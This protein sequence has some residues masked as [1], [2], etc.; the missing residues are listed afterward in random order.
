M[1]APSWIPFM[2]HAM[3]R[4]DPMS[5]KSSFSFEPGAVF[6]FGKAFSETVILLRGISGEVVGAV[7]RGMLKQVSSWA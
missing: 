6:S 3:L 1:A 5:R 2:L 7:D 4:S